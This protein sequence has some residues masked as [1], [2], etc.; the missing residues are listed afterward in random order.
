[1]T[2][3]HPQHLMH[4]F[5]VVLFRETGYTCY[6]CWEEDREQKKREE[7]IRVLVERKDIDGLLRL[8]RTA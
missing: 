5:D 1:M 7:K 2:S 6:K 8:L 4:V 3:E